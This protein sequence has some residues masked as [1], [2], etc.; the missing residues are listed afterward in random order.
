MILELEQDNFKTTWRMGRVIL[1]HFLFNFC[2]EKKNLSFCKNLS[3]YLMWLRNW[4][5]TFL[6]TDTSIYWPTT[7]VI[8]NQQV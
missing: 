8:L 4:N 3:F 7:E 1:F 2:F 6:L 5:M